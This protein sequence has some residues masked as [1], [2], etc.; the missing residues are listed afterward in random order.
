MF[1]LP[2]RP[3]KDYV[4][5]EVTNNLLSSG[6]FSPDSLPRVTQ[7]NLGRFCFPIEYNEDEHCDKNF[8]TEINPVIM[9][10]LINDARA[11]WV[12]QP[13][14]DDFFLH[15]VYKKHNVREDPK[16]LDPRYHIRE[17]CF[18]RSYRLELDCIER[19]RL[20]KLHKKCER[21]H[22][23][24]ENYFQYLVERQKRKEK[25]RIRVLPCKRKSPKWWKYSEKKTKA[26]TQEPIEY[27]TP[28]ADES[29][30]AVSYERWQEEP[31][32]TAF[33]EDDPCRRKMD[34]LLVGA[35]FKNEACNWYYNKYPPPN[36][37]LRFKK[38]A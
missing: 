22:E 14:K 32:L 5:R 21:E 1:T 17:R 23:D 37:K 2:P 7:P 38:F 16:S 4:I 9:E 36:L 34:M 18:P 11:M 26:D 30:Y 25:P 24:F 12:V 10:K 3:P 6:Q 20:E 29:T 15:D 8:S 28:A 35:Q 19:A 13:G 33:V 27:K 31:N